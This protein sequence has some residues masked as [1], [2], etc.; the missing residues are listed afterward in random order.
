MLDVC[1]RRKRTTE[2]IHRHGEQRRDRILAMLVERA[3]PAPAMKC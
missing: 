2:Q 3:T 1:L